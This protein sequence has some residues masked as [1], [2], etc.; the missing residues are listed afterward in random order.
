MSTVALADRRTVLCVSVCL[1]LSVCLSVFFKD[2]TGAFELTTYTH[3]ISSC[4]YLRSKWGRVLLSSR[5]SERR[6]SMPCGPKRRRPSALRPALCD[7][8]STHSLSARAG[9]RT[10]AQTHAQIHA[11]T[12]TRT[13]THTCTCSCI[14]TQTS[15]PACMWEW[16]FFSVQ[17]TPSF[18]LFRAL[19]ET[20]PKL[21]I[22]FIE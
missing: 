18:V 11:Q 9:V 15:E 21:L 4:Q 7:G 5:A 12:H 14:D 19:Y 13:R 3:T 8:D 6:Q 16:A 22:P 2:G 20:H 1:C 10:H 17:L